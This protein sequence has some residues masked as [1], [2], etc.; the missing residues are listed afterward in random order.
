M[1]TSTNGAIALLDNF[2]GAVPPCP[3]ELD[4]PQIWR[5]DQSGEWVEY[6]N[7]EGDIYTALFYFSTRH[8]FGIGKP[9]GS[10]FVVRTI[11]WGSPLDEN[12]QVGDSAP[13]AHPQRFRV[14]LD[15]C[16]TPSGSVASRLSFLSGEKAGEIIDDTGEATG[17]LAEACDLAA[18]R[19]WGKSFTSA[20]LLDYADNA[21][22]KTDDEVKH[23]ARRVSRFLDAISDEEGEDDE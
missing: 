20:L 13:S 4:L 9:V 12:G 10:A 19:V 23:L 21:K 8:Q 5:L 7:T 2:G 22:T 14:A 17:A 11:G 1:T 3:P 6:P 15:I 18:F 16:A